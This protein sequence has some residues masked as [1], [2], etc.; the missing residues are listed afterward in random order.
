MEGREKLSAYLSI[1]CTPGF[2]NLYYLTVLKM[3]LAAFGHLTHWPKR[4]P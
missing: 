2:T 3:R 1:P 4:Y